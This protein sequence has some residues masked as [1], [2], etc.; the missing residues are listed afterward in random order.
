M[1]KALGILGGMGPQA[2][3]DLQQKIL[4]FTESRRDQDHLRIYVDNHP[5]IPD[6]IGA[7]L[8]NT[9]SPVPAMPESLD[10]L[11]AMGA[12]CIVR[13]CVSAH[14][15]LSQLVV[16]PQVVFLDML[17]ITAGMCARQYSNLKA[18]VLCSVATAQSGLLAPY[19]ER[20]AIPYLYPQA[21]DQQLL[22]RLILEVK[23]RADLSAAADA[24]HAVAREMSS[25][26]ADYF[27]LACTEL[28]II[29][30]YR[31]LQYTCLDAT[32]ELAKVAILCCGYTLN[33]TI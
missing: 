25:R 21:K 31:P 9:L 32:G 23:A 8:S 4:N 33:K 29:A 16:P 17:Q 5:Q 28:P 22:G 20:F 19:L 7:V 6:R 26:G 1:K 13:P 10:K 14:Y 2:T 30:Q 12:G 18:G 3:I 24:L 27:V 11:G 15:F